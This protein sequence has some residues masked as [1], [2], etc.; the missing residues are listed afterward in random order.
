MAKKGRGR[1]TMD[2]RRSAKSNAPV[3]AADLKAAAR[4]ALTVIDDDAPSR[5][6][7]A[8]TAVLP[9]PVLELAADERE[10]RVRRGAD[11]ILLDEIDSTGKRTGTRGFVKAVLR[12]P[13]EHPAA[14]VYG[15]W[16]EVEKSAYLSLKLAHKEK[17][18]ARVRG[19]LATRLPL[20]E[21]AFGAEVEILEDG[22]EMRARITAARHQLIKDGPAI[23]PA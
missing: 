11:T 8:I 21:D 1:S 13:L 9:D 15:V 23:G 12:V 2:S 18:Q 6:E 4:R 19:T 10:R 5:A 3:S 17:Q 7:T 16:V 14:Q 22:S 20:L